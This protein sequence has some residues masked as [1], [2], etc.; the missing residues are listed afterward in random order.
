M[1]PGSAKKLDAIG[2]IVHS[3]NDDVGP[4][5]EGLQIGLGWEIMGTNV[6]KRIDG[7]DCFPD[8]V[9]LLPSDGVGKA[10]HLSIHVRRF[11]KVLTRDDQFFHPTA[12]QND[13]DRLPNPG[14]ADDQHARRGGIG[15]CGLP[16]SA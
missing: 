2:E 16:V 4:G 3:R 13:G 1:S 9:D 12:C 6:G 11:I 7:E 10:T 8:H 14:I 5:H 15:R